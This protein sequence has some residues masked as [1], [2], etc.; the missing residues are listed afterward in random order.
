MKSNIVTCGIAF[1]AMAIC[2]AVLAQ[3]DKAIPKVTITV[4][5]PADP[6]GPDKMDTI[7]G[8]VYGDC[9]KCKIMVYAKGDAWYVQPFAN[10][11]DTAINDAKWTADTHLGM[12]YAAVLARADWHPPAKTGS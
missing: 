7:S 4:V 5:P 9:P 1:L 12:E 11:T 10:Q 8:E 2:T 3:T 6:G